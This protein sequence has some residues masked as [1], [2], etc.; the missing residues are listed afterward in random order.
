MDLPA[1]NIVLRWFR[2]K[3][4]IHALCQ[5]KDDIESFVKNLAL[6]PARV[7]APATSV[8]GIRLAR[9]NCRAP[10]QR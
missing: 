2:L 8:F 3:R 1:Q 7:D 10:A 5:P 4:R 9:L 6:R